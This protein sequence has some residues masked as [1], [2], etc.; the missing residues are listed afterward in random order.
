MTIGF[1]GIIGTKIGGF[2][3][4]AAKA[5]AED[6]KA[7]ELLELALKNTTGASDTQVAAVEEWIDATARQTGIADDELRPALGNLVRA[8]EDVDEAQELMAVS[9]DI[10]T[11]KGLSLESVTK[12]V[13]KGADGNTTALSK[14]GIQMKDADGKA[15][16][17]EEAMAEAARTMGGAT[18]VAAST[19]E[20]RMR[21]MKVTIDEAKESI[22]MGMLPVL[23]DMAEVG[24]DVATVIGF[25]SEKLAELSA[26]AGGEPGDESIWTQIMRFTGFKPVIDGLAFVADAIEETG[27]AADTTGP[28]LEATITHYSNMA[29]AT[30]DATVA[31]DSFEEEVRSQ[32]DPIFNLISKIEDLDA[33]Q[34]NT[35]DT[36]IEYGEGSAEHRAALRKE[37]EAWLGVKDAQIKAATEAGLTR[38]AFKK[39]LSDMGVFTNAEIDLILEDFDR[40]NDYKFRDKVV[41]VRVARGE[42]IGGGSEPRAAGGP[43]SAGRSYLVGN[44]ARR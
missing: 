32:I 24:G 35:A 23:G 28:K 19:F 40:V 5:A 39:V 10:A 30:D 1:A 37:A 6:Q 11:A 36:L 42:I 29:E 2:L 15:I 41:N 16:S 43:V 25:I 7:Q 31:L 4:D 18:A 44:A 38:D 21:I 13:A 34:R 14:L 27:E 26:I 12:A 9:M 3:L 8:T 33:A 22:G 20:G 17:F